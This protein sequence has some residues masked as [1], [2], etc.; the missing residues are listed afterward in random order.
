[1]NAEN[2]VADTGNEALDESGNQKSKQYRAGHR[3][4]RQN[5]P[6]QAV[7]EC[8]PHDPP[9]L[10]KDRVPIA[11]KEKYRKHHQKQLAYASANA[12]CQRS[13]LAGPRLSPSGNLC[14]EARGFGRE[15]IK[16]PLQLL[17]E[18]RDSVNDLWEDQG[19]LGKQCFQ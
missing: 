5:V 1:M 19:L 13:D 17:S 3:A 8:T 7:A 18:P 4:G 10:N 16:L 11:I 9:Q 2:R 12:A 6:V 14:A 15:A